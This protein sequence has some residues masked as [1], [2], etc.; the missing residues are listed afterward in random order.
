MLKTYIEQ[1]KRPLSQFETLS[2]DMHRSIFEGLSLS[3]YVYI[4]SFVCNK[5]HKKPCDVC[6]RMIRVAKTVSGEGFLKLKTAFEMVSP[7]VTYTALHARRKLLQMP[8]VSIGVG[9][10][11]KGTYSVFLVEKQSAVHYT[12][13]QSLLNNWMSCQNKKCS[14]SLGK[15][16]VNDLL[17]LAE[18]NGER[19]RLKY[20]IVKAAGI[21]HSQA[22]SVYGF[23][24]MSSRV[25]KVENALLE[26]TAIRDAIENIANIKET[27]LLSSFGISEISDDSQSESMDDESETDTNNSENEIQPSF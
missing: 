8:L 4:R 12:I 16:T 6:T 27:A 23:D 25:N 1:T 3:D 14:N 7:N 15:E 13:F 17:K 18:S 21:S 5:N 11:K 10:R 9:E 24:N 26:A 19:E 20:A 2:S 22:K